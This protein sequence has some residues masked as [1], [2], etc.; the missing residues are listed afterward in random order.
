MDYFNSKEFIN[1][2]TKKATTLKE[3][4]NMLMSESFVK[5]MKWTSEKDTKG[6]WIDAIHVDIQLYDGVKNVTFYANGGA[7]MINGHSFSWK[8]R[9]TD[10]EF[11]KF[12]ETTVWIDQCFNTESMYSPYYGTKRTEMKVG[13]DVLF[14]V[15]DANTMSLLQ[16]FMNKYNLTDYEIKDW[17][18]VLHGNWNN[19]K[20]THRR[21]TWNNLY[22]D[23]LAEASRRKI[24]IVSENYFMH[25]GRARF[26]VMINMYI[27]KANHD[28]YNFN[29]YN[30]EYCELYKSIVP[31][32]ENP[33]IRN[34]SLWYHIHH[35]ICLGEWTVGYLPNS[36]K[37]DFNPKKFNKSQAEFINYYELKD[38]ICSSVNNDLKHKFLDSYKN[39]SRMRL[40]M[41]KIKNE[42]Y[43]NVVNKTR[44]LLSVCKFKKAEKVKKE[45][46]YE[47]HPK[48]YESC[49][50][51]SQDRP[52]FRRT[53]NGKM[54]RYKSY[55]TYEIVK[56]YLK[57]KKTA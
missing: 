1:L 31:R 21:Y 37:E 29:K 57:N 41:F 13:H 35:Q 17:G 54:I 10:E 4:E 24:A 14:F 22:P 46:D 7:H 23:L 47:E 5:R 48:S 2:Y 26:Q 42:F 30:A 44:E 45:K 52:Y 11:K 27:A 25:S 55:A 49:S 51:F 12:I 16:D 50:R 32:V 39:P 40:W 19:K 53:K 38:I 18:N 6:K 15:R 36:H 28:D 3:I 56:E 8:R 34:K 20:K 33:Q 9:M 43:T